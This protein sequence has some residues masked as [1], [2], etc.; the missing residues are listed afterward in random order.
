M[1]RERMDALLQYGGILYLTSL[2]TATHEDKEKLSKESYLTIMF[3]QVI[4]HQSYRNVNE[5]L[6]NH[7]N[8]KQD[9]H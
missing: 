1:E 4:E 5:D 3:V 2:T 7:L 8:L 9:N 6:S